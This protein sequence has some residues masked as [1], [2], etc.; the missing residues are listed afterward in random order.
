MEVVIP[1]LIVSSIEE[2]KAAMQ[3]FRSL[4]PNETMKITRVS[5]SCTLYCINQ[6]CYAI[7]GRVK[8]AL[9]WH[10]FD[11]ESLESLLL[12]SHPNWLPSPSDIELGRKL[13]ARAFEQPAY[14]YVQ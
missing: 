13:L 12:T 7:E 6:N 3:Q 1:G 2:L 8:G 5:G 9:T 14:A 4:Q 11:K 10:L